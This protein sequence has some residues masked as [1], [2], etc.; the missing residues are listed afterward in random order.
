VTAIHERGSSAGTASAER[1]FGPITRTDIVRYAGASGDFN[2]IHHDHVF[3]T[4]SGYPSVFG[5]GLLTAGVLSTFVTGWLGRANLRR[6]SVRYVDQVW[7]GDSL[8][9]R[10]ELDELLTAESPD[11]DAGGVDVHVRLTV[12]ARTGEAAEERLVLTGHAVARFREGE[13]YP[14][15]DGGTTA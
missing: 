15:C 4:S 12:H 8:V 11:G 3:A 9:T 2:P 7:P 13:P 10:G 5:H 14:G 6:F 1:V